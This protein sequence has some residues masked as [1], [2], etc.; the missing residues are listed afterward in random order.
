MA[1]AAHFKTARIVLAVLLLPLCW[2]AHAQKPAEQTA[3]IEA[4]Q[5]PNRQGRDGLTLQQVMESLHVPGLSIAVVRN[6]Q[7]DWTKSYGV[8]DVDTG[9]PVQPDTLFQ[10][11]SISKAVTAMAVLRLV[12]EQRVSLDADVNAY[13]KGWRVP[14]SD[15]TRQQPVTLRSLLSHTSGED[16]VSG[17]PGYMPGA[18]LP[19]VVQILLG[20]PPSNTGPVVFRRPPYVAYKYSGVG[21]EIVQLLLTDVVGQPFEAILQNKVL[22]PLGMTDSTF[23]QPLPERLAARAAR[24]H[25][26]NGA[27]LDVP[28]RVYPE[29]SAAGLWTT[30]SDLAKFVIEVQRALRGPAGAVLAEPTAREI[31]A[32]VG[33]GPFGAGLAVSQRGEGWYFRFNGANDGYRCSLVGHFRKGYGL[34]VMTNGENGE[35]VFHE[36]EDRVAAAYGW[37]TLDKPVPRD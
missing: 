24:G 9:R 3:R 36:V 22:A 16:N 8:S 11:A 34:V 6:F 15:L 1:P 35:A 13:L 37:D 26:A 28:W 10:A 31:V 7:V 27:R 29:L 21:L 20:Q 33:V 5:V 12:Q 23:A 18:V 4:P 32:P 17:F 30:A 2:T 19:N 14:E 25:D